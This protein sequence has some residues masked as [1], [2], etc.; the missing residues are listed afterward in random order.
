MN[1]ETMNIMLATIDQ[2]KNIF[3]FCNKSMN[4]QLLL[5]FLH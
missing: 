4:A 2:L 5:T 1:I 3:S